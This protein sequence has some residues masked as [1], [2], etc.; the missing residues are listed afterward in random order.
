VLRHPSSAPLQ[1]SRTRRPTE[2]ALGKTRDDPTSR[3]PPLSERGLDWCPWD[4]AQVACGKSHC[5]QGCRRDHTCN[6]SLLWAPVPS[7]GAGRL[8]SVSGLPMGGRRDTGRS[9]R[10]WRTQRLQSRV[11]TTPLPARSPR[12]RQFTARILCPAA[13]RGRTSRSNV[14]TPPRQSPKRPSARMDE[15][16]GN[17]RVPESGGGVDGRST[18]R[19]RRRG[20]HVETACYRRLSRTML[21]VATER[22]Q[23]GHRVLGRCTGGRRRDCAR[24]N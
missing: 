14:D 8:R 6:M 9:L 4:Q 11:R 15:P 19:R 5:A 24:G 2:S 20:C 18:Q 12:A 13:A 22:F 7:C 10:G 1:A 3:R 17:E 16:E 21:R 23:R